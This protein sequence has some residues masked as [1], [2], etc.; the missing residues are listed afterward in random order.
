MIGFILAENTTT[1]PCLH[2][3]SDGDDM[4]LNVCLDACLMRN[5]DGE[6]N[7]ASH[8][9]LIITCLGGHATVQDYT[10]INVFMWPAVY[11]FRN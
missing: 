3:P 9:L 1:I 6:N 10:V 2:L 11:A 8:L 7:T 4:T 5:I